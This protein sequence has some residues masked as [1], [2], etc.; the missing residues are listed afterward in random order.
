MNKEMKKGIRDF[1][2]I[3]NPD[4]KI[5]FQ[6]WDL[7]CDVHTDTI[8]IGKTF[9]KRT[10]EYFKNFCKILNPETVKINSFLLSILHEIGHIETWTEE[11]DEQKNVL[12]DILKTQFDEEELDNEKMAEY[13][14]MYFKIPLEQNATEWGINYALTHLDLMQQFDWLHN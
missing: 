6:K 9:D 7:E 13:C 5:K 10:D 4:L 12:Y 11:D 14:D 2:N 1:I 3:I 8:Y